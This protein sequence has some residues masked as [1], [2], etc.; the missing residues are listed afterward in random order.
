M[1]E[2]EHRQRAKDHE[3]STV[4]E[5]QHITTDRVL[6]PSMTGNND[7]FFIRWDPP[8]AESMWNEELESSK[9]SSTVT[10]I[11]YVYSETETMYETVT[12]KSYTIQGC[13][14]PYLDFTPC[15]STQMTQSTVEQPSEVIELLGEDTG[16]V[17]VWQHELTKNITPILI[18]SSRV[19]DYEE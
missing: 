8:P 16:D 12:T 6:E 11:I 9:L 19:G 1:P 4:R 18:E 5:E 17:P 2:D 7:D 14:P 15:P 13:I 10:S 3:K